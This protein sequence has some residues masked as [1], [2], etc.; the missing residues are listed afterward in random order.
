M[1]NKK[2]WLYYNYAH[3]T[4]AFRVEEFGYQEAEPNYAFKERRENII[5]HYILNG[6]CTVQM[7]GQEKLTLH[8]GQAVIIRKKVSYQCVADESLPCTRFWMALDGENVDE[9]LNRIESGT[10]VISG[11]DVIEM[12]NGAKKLYKA[13]RSGMDMAFLTLSQACGALDGLAKGVARNGETGRSRDT[14]KQRILQA[15]K[16]YIDSRL[17]SKISVQELAY[18]F[19]YERSY[20]YRIFMEENGISPQKYIVSWRIQKAKRLLMETDLP[21]SQIASQVGYESYAS[22]TKI[23]IKETGETPGGFRNKIK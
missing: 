9:A 23:F 10:A 3:V 21:I 6:K 1:A 17:D 22:F 11:V 8:K 5:I 12:E 16:R 2:F 14:D 7:D 4:P 19:G 15:V 20:L 18:K 13:L